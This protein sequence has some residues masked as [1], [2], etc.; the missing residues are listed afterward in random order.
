MQLQCLLWWLLN[1][2]RL[3]KKKNGKSINAFTF[4]SHLYSPQIPGHFPHYAATTASMGAAGAIAWLME[5]RYEPMAMAIS[6]MIG[7][8]SGVICDGAS[9]SCAMKVSTG[10]KCRL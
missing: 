3:V 2:Y 9:N 7:D 1:I 4:I 5:E 8:I 10:S 6:S